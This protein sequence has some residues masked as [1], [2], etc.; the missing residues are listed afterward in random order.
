M[1]PKLKGWLLI[2]KGGTAGTPKEWCIHHGYIAAV[3]KAMMD[4]SL[5]S[6]LDQSNLEALEKYM[7]SEE[8][9]NIRL[10][11]D[12]VGEKV[13]SICRARSE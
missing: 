9:K 2:S 3:K 8:V 6:L 1:L 7:A 10:D 13:R 11:V 12:I 5:S 4:Q